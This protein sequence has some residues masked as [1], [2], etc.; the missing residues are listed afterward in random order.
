MA[1]RTVFPDELTGKAFE[2]FDPHDNL[3]LND[4]ASN[5]LSP[6]L[7]ARLHKFRLHLQAHPSI[8]NSFVLG[9]VL[10]MFTSQVSRENKIVT[11][12]LHVGGQVVLLFAQMPEGPHESAKAGIIVFQYAQ[13]SSTHEH[14]KL[15]K[16]IVDGMKDAFRPLNGDVLIDD[17]LT[18]V[19][20]V[21]IYQKSTPNEF[22]YYDESYRLKKS[23]NKLLQQSSKPYSVYCTMSHVDV[24]HDERVLPATF[25]RIVNPQT[26]QLPFN[27]ME[28]PKPMTGIF[29][30]PASEGLVPYFVEM[31]QWATKYFPMLKIVVSKENILR[32]M[33]G[34]L[35]S[36]EYRYDIDMVS[37]Y[38][39]RGNVHDLTIMRRIQ[40]GRFGKSGPPATC[41]ITDTDFRVDSSQQ[42]FL[43]VGIDTEVDSFVIH[44]IKLVK[45][46][47]YHCQHYIH[48][49]RIKKEQSLFDVMS[50]NVNAVLL[51]SSYINEAM[52]RISQHKKL[53]T[54]HLQL[55]VLGQ[56]LGSK[57]PDAMLG[58]FAYED[59][60]V[61]SKL[62]TF[63]MVRQQTVYVVNIGDAHANRLEKLS[64]YWALR[65]HLSRL[66][67]N[68][69]VVYN[70][71]TKFHTNIEHRLRVSGVQWYI[72]NPTFVYI[73]PVN[74]F[75]SH[76]FSTVDSFNV[77][78]VHDIP[79][80]QYKG[81]L[82]EIK[83]NM[84]Q[85]YMKN[86]LFEHTLC[87]KYLTDIAND[88][89][90]TI[91]S[92]QQ[93][94]TLFKS[95][96][97]LHGRVLMPLKDE[98]NIFGIIFEKMGN[99]EVHVLHQIEFFE[100][101]KDLRLIKE[102]FVNK[103]G[104]FKLNNLLMDDVELRLSIRFQKMGQMPHKKWSLIYASCTPSTSVVHT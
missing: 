60:T 82:I 8:L 21:H 75:D 13:P 46:G 61:A 48:K 31:S 24:V 74:K 103:Y 90:H 73:D 5:A 58:I 99:K 33:Q 66:N 40:T 25:Y 86:F 27:H 72:H 15:D 57:A 91:T 77:N 37:R 67:V 14:Y 23:H 80:G 7:E 83:N 97:S 32:L 43:P 51:S 35:I 28:A 85:H 19:K 3:R 78:D 42:I 10:G 68:R 79:I 12:H 41:L 11:P 81:K 92:P 70:I 96:I 47:R 6:R 65:P 29:F 50:G 18:R 9:F 4:F 16:S 22:S 30:Q 56:L 93:I 20:F 45:I 102:E 100:L 87:V 26:G 101:K 84:L 44:H 55:W 95:F 17:A 89:E 39:G 94:N 63:L 38:S 54:K 88:F 1:H 34:G 104:K 76:V 49:Q 2:T 71:E 59:V 62:K 98:P 69:I 53:K 64:L 52:E 36:H